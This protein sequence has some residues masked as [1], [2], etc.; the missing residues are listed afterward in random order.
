MT[1]TSAVGRTWTRRLVSG[2][3]RG[4]GAPGPNGTVVRIMGQLVPLDSRPAA[5]SLLA[6]PRTERSD[7][8]ADW[9]RSRDLTY[10]EAEALMALD[11]TTSWSA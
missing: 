2:L 5:R 10:G 4:S 7:L 11:E 9:T 8:L 1:R 3:A 6:R